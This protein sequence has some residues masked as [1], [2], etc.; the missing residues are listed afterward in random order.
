MKHLFC[1]VALTLVSRPALAADPC[2]YDNARFLFRGPANGE[3]IGSYRTDA[4]GPLALVQVH[5]CRRPDSSL[6]V[7]LGHAAI[8]GGPLTAASI[9]TDPPVEVLHSQMTDRGAP[10]LSPDRRQHVVLTSIPG[11]SIDHRD[12]LLLEENERSGTL[13]VRYSTGAE[14]L[15]QRQTRP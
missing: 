10:G 2:D 4:A 7:L 5:F 11:G 1:V 12:L 8:P 9:V 6:Y 14:R 15:L 3:L 13:R